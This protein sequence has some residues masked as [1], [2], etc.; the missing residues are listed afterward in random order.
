[1]NRVL[2]RISRSPYHAPDRRWVAALL[3]ELATIPGR[4]ARM[5]WLLGATGMLFGH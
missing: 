4:R 1:M 3:A 2:H 5:L